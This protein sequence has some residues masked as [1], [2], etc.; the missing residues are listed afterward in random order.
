MT[1]IA[2]LPQ[3]ASERAFD[4]LGCI[5][6]VGQSGRRGFASTPSPTAWRRCLPCS[7]TTASVQQH[8]LHHFG[9]AATFGEPVTAMELSR[10]APGY[11]LIRALPGSWRMSELIQ[12]TDRLPTYKQRYSAYCAQT[13]ET[14]HPK[15]ARVTGCEKW[16]GQTGEALAK[17]GGG[18]RQ[19]SPP[20]GTQRRAGF[21][22]DDE[23]GCNPQTK[24]I[25]QWKASIAFGDVTKAD[26]LTQLVMR[27]S[28]PDKAPFIAFA[29]DKLKQLGVSEEIAFIKTTRC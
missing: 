22:V 17:N 23:W 28:P 25:S 20:E 8:N 24:L 14:G 2:G 18:S 15:C 1:R 4:M 29:A 26:R 5:C 12:I 7:G 13:G 6:P 11:R 19:K 27:L 10:T 16:S 21:T 9:W 3:A